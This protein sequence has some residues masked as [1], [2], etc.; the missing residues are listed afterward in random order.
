[1]S[2]LGKTE[3]IFIQPA[4]KVNCVYCCDEVL[5]KGLLPV[6]RRLSG[7]DFTFQ[8]DAAPSHQSKHTVAYLKT[9]V[10]SFIQPSNWPPNSPDL[11]LVDYSIW[12]ALQQ[13]VYRWKIRDL[14]HLKEVLQDCWTMISQDSVDSAIDQFSKRLTLFIRAQGG[15]IEHRHE[16]GLIRRTR[17]VIKLCSI[18]KN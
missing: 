7:N 1:V 10:P 8:Q 14:E 18:L 2:H 12:G 3:L 5:A 4:A 16:L 6:T 9:N 17:I 13:L 11:N 15:H